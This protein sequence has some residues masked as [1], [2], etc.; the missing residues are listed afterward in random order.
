MT[1]LYAL[2]SEGEQPDYRLSIPGG[3][4]WLNSNDPTGGRLFYSRRRV[5]TQW[6]AAGASHA[7]QARIPQLTRAY[8][9]AELCFTDRRRRDPANFYPTVKAAVDGLVD[10]GV[11]VD[12]S[13]DYLVGPDMRLGPSVAGRHYP[14]GLLI[15]KLFVLPDPPEPKENR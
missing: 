5:I 7:R 14:R 15:L 1:P 10:A 3:P 4:G 6:R 12:D 2:C 9:L 11:L 8:I 13:P